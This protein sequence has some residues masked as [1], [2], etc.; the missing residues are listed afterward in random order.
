MPNK[1]SRETFM[2]A[3][4]SPRE[5]AVK[6]GRTSDK[7]GVL[8]LAVMACL[9]LILASWFGS[10]VPAL[11]VALVGVAMAVKNRVSRAWTMTMYAALGIAGFTLLAPVFVYYNFTAMMPV[12]LAT[13]LYV[14]GAMATK[15]RKGAKA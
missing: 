14:F 12:I 4:A 5:V 10:V 13:A 7:Q 11:L 2:G 9:A 1:S 6:G 15:A 3:W 8:A